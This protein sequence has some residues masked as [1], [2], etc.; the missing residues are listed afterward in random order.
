MSLSFAF[1]AILLCQSA[2]SQAP[3]CAGKQ[4]LV[5]ANIGYHVLAL[6]SVCN[7]CLS[8]TCPA[9]LYLLHTANF[10]PVTAD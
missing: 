6:S 4:G 1:P 10:Q 9:P 5:L 3:A 2:C 7:H 8:F